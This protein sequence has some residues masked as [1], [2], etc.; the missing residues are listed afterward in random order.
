LAKVLI[1]KKLMYNE[2]SGSTCGQTMNRSVRFLFNC[3]KGAVRKP[4][5]KKLEEANMKL[6]LFGRSTILFIV[7]LVLCFLVVPPALAASSAVD[8]PGPT[9]LS[10]LLIWLTS[11]GGAVILL[12][13][14][15]SWYLEGLTWW[16]KLT[17]QNRSLIIL[18]GALVLG[19]LSV[20]VQTQPALIVTLDPYF[21]AAM[22]I[23]SVWI[24][25]QTAHKLDPAR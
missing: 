21:K 24:V 3:S 11:S 15:A 13:W 14:A 6:S 18:V 10:S 16:Q 20:W 5:P 23:I 7:V 1:E 17:S 2:S 25:T 12:A 8:S 22:G 4:L 19:L 9:D